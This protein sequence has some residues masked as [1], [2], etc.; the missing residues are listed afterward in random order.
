MACFCVDEAYGHAST[1]GPYFHPLTSTLSAFCPARPLP[2]SPSPPPL[3]PPQA[4]FPINALR[5]LAIEQ[6]RTDL[7]FLIEGDMLVPAGVRQRL[8]Q[9]HLPRMLSQPDGIATAWI[10]PLFEEVIH[11]AR[12]S[13][14]NQR[15]HIE[16]DPAARQVV[17]T[18]EELLAVQTKWAACTLQSHKYLRD[19]AEYWH[20][21]TTPLHVNLRWSQEPYYIVNRR[22]ALQ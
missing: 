2:L 14:R 21:A 10:V 11:I 16:P 20:S 19:A 5:N 7:V 1:G 12:P 22:S 3:P 18:K 9:D 8:M 15:V 4:L 13:L 6:A 17:Q